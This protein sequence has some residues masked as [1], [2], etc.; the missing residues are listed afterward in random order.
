MKEDS[1]PEDEKKRG[2]AKIQKMTDKYIAEV[3]AA[4]KKKE[5]EVMEI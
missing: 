2:E 4:F 5:A 1:L 3:E